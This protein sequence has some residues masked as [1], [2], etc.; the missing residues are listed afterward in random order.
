MATPL[1]RHHV[2]DIQ[3]PGGGQQLHRRKNHLRLGGDGVALRVDQ[4]RLAR[5]HVDQRTLAQRALLHRHVQ[6]GAR[7]LRL[8]EQQARAQLRGVQPLPGIAHRLLDGAAQVG[9]RAARELGRSDKTHG[10]FRKGVH[11]IG[12]RCIASGH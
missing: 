4:R 11:Q 2:L 10:L 9:K 3:L 6:E 1:P 7:D 5:Q 8:V 12:A